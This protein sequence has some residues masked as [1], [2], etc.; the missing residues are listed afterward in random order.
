ME[1]EQLQANLTKSVEELKAK[2]YNH[3]CTSIVSDGEYKQV[4]VTIDNK[5][6]IIRDTNDYVVEY[7]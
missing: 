2:G 5:K 4:W 7:V 1:R 6:A 3:A